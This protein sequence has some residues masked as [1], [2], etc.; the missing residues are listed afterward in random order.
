MN[1]ATTRAFQIAKK[2]FLIAILIAFLI[3]T[4][5]ILTGS[6]WFL[7]IAAYSQIPWILISPSEI[8]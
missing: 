3:Q 4:L 8:I 5:A 6:M 7:I 2:S 1:S